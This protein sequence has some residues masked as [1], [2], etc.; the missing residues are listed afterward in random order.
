M[1][2]EHENIVGFDSAILMHPTVWKASGHVGNFIDVMV[3]DTITKERFRYDTLSD[4]QREQ[5][6]S[7]NGNPLSE[8]KNFNLM[9]STSL[10]STEES[11]MKVY[12]RPETAQGIYVNFKNVQQ[13][14]RLKLPFGI[15]QV[16][17]AFR[18][19]LLF[20]NFIFRTCEFEQ[21]E[22]QFFVH[23]QEDTKWFEHWKQLRMQY[24]KDIGIRESH[25]RFHE[26][27]P[28]ELAH[29]AKE[30]CDV[31]YHF[32][33]GW[34]EIEGI[35]NRSNFDLTQHSEFSKKDLSYQ[36]EEGEKFIPCIIETSAGL[37]RTVLLVLCDAYRVEEIEGSARTVL[38]LHPRLAPYTIAVLPLVKKD[39]LA[40][41]AKQLFLSLQKEYSCAFDVNTS[42]GKRYRRQDEIGTPLCLT[43]DYDSL[44]DSSVTIRQRDT[45]KQERVAIHK[46]NQYISDYVKTYGVDNA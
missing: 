2:Q 20:K 18:N 27:R 14:S 1:V 21:M 13:T 44:T 9:F 15:A 32:P 6:L 25:L 46:I 33:F 34:N 39:G 38:Q 35:H 42:I 43:Y 26:H 41:R 10:G 8:P 17:K 24:Y 40:E 36:P 7:P 37:T 12:L 28:D 45:L 16:G 30:A 11:S 5:N 31:F 4:V 29:Y 23:P 3:E 19:E 22:M